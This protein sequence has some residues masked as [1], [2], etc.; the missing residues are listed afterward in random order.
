VKMFA[1]D[2]FQ[3]NWRVQIDA[4]DRRISMETTKERGSVLRFVTVRK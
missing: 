2:L 4:V 3:Y 1:A